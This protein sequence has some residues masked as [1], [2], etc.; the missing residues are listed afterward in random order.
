VLT[1]YSYDGSIAPSAPSASSLTAGLRDLYRDLGKTT[2]GFPPMLFWQLLRQHVP[3]F[4]EM[5]EGHPAQQ[6]A[7]ECWTQILSALKTS[8][9]GGAGKTFVSQYMT[10]ELAVTVK[11]AEAPDEPPQVTRETFTDLKWCGD[12]AG[13]IADDAATSPPRPTTRAPGSRSR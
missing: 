9:P 13:G 1:L 6:D 5:R 2:E 11:C 3:Q 8:L 10:G 7:E 12:R 4:Q